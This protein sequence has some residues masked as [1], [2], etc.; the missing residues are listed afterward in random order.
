MA[1]TLPAWTAVPWAV[2]IFAVAII[3]GLGVIESITVAAVA[4]IGWSVA[5][6]VLGAMA[7]QR[8][9]SDVP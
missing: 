2:L 4:T 1:R 8:G 9:G 6:Q 5:R 3:A 7:G